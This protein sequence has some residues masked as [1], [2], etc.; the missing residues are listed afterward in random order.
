[1][2]RVLARD[3]ELDQCLVCRGLW[4]DHREIDE[5]FAL[6]NIPARFLDQQQYGESPVMIGEGSRVCP[7]CDRDLRIVEVDGVK[8]DACSRCH[9]IFTDLGELKQLAKAAERRFRE[10][11]KRGS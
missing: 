1:M 11:Q 9:G 6:E 8:L 7:R 4:L 5:L 10:F 2:E 3:T